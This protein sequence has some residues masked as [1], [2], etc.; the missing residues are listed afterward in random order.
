MK[1]SVIYDN[2]EKVV[3]AKTVAS[4]HGYFK[5][6]R[7]KQKPR[8]V[9]GNMKCVAMILLAGASLCHSSTDVKVSAH[10]PQSGLPY[11][12]SITTIDTVP[13]PAD[14]TGYNTLPYTGYPYPGLPYAAPQEVGED[15]DQQ[16]QR[17]LALD[18]YA[19]YPAYSGYSPYAGYAGYLHAAYTR[20]PHAGYGGYPHTGY[21]DYSANGYPHAGHAGYPVDGYG[22]YPA[23]VNP[24]AGYTGLPAGYNGLLAVPAAPAAKEDN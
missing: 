23:A 24:W 22:G 16:I 18:G 21:A 20:Y 1:E 8:P 6:P 19:G 15:V 7:I 14:T 11:S 17:V 5:N 10:D 4:E 9:P 2:L 12:Y 13:T 3:I